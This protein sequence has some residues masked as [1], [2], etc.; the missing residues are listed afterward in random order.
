MGFKLPGM[1]KEFS[2]LTLN[3]HHYKYDELLELCESQILLEGVPQWESAI[4]RF[5]LEWLSDEEYVVVHT[6]GS[7]GAPKVIHQPKERMITSARM[8][9]SYFRLD[10]KTNALLC[11]PVSYIAGK[12]MVVRAFVTGMNLVIV[13]PSSN[14]FTRVNGKINFAAITPFQLV[15]SLNQLNE[16]PVDSVIV[17]GGEIPYDLEIA[18]QK[19]SSNVYATYGMT[20][21]SSHIAIRAVNGEQ[22]S[23]FYEVLNGVAISVDKRGCLVINAPGLTSDQLITNDVVSIQDPSHFE[24]IG[25]IDSVINSGGIKIFPEQV[26]KKLFP[27]IAG[28]FFIAGLPDKLLGEK[29]ALF[30][31]GEPLSQIQLENLNSCMTAILSK[32]EIPRMV[33]SVLAF[34]LSNAGKILKKKIAARFS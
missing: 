12:M 27:L 9:A 7:T 26:E 23:P 3:G 5:V 2:S 25:R 19:L 1:V 24:W 11:L 28:R 16:N 22:R 17:G 8:T 4:Y 18:C 30:V 6:S 20:E 15:H 14:P 32:F 31:E 34:D 29:V 33:V 13:D 21:T 10:A